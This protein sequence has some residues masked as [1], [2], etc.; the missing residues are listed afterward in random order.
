MCLLHAFK[1]TENGPHNG[2]FL[3]EKRLADVAT[4]AVAASPGGLAS[5]IGKGS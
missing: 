5:G 4:V 2:L 1:K 3:N